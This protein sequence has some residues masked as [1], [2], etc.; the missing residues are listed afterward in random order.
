MGNNQKCIH[1][2]NVDIGL[3]STV[4]QDNAGQ[5]VSGKVA[6]RFDLPQPPLEIERSR[7]QY[8][9]VSGCDRSRSMFNFNTANDEDNSQNGQKRPLHPT[10][11]DQSNNNNCLPNLSTLGEHCDLLK[12]LTGRHPQKAPSCVPNSKGKLNQHPRLSC[13]NDSENVHSNRSDPSRRI[14]HLNRPQFKWSPGGVEQQHS[15]QQYNQQQYKQQ[16]YNQQQYNQ[17]QYEQELVV[18]NNPICQ[19]Q[20]PQPIAVCH[21]KHQYE[22]LHRQY[23]HHQ[24]QYVDRQVH[25]DTRSRDHY[26]QSRRSS[27]QGPSSS[28]RRNFR[29]LTDCVCSGKDASGYEHGTKGSGNLEN[30][31]S[32]DA[33]K[34]Y[35]SKKTTPTCVEYIECPASRQRDPVREKKPIKKISKQFIECPGSSRRVKRPHECDCGNCERKIIIYCTKRSNPN[36]NNPEDYDEYPRS[37]ER[38]V[39]RND[40][41]FD[42]ASQKVYCMKMWN[43][44]T[45]QYSEC[46]SSRQRQMRQKDNQQYDVI[47]DESVIDSRNVYFNGPI[48]N[49]KQYVECPSLKRVE[50]KRQNKDFEDARSYF[51]RDQ[52]KLLDSSNSKYCDCNN[53]E[54]YPEEMPY[55]NDCDCQ[56]QDTPKV[57]LFCGLDD[58]DEE[59]EKRSEADDADTDATY[60]EMQPPVE[61][62]Q[63]DITYA[64]PQ[65]NEASVETEID[66][67]LR[68]RNKEFCLSNCHPSCKL[69]Q[70]IQENGAEYSDSCVETEID[71]TLNSRSGECMCEKDDKTAKPCNKKE[72]PKGK[73]ANPSAPTVKPKYSMA[74]K[75]LKP[76]CKCPPPVPDKSP[77]KCRPTSPNPKQRSVSAGPPKFCGK[78]CNKVEDVSGKCIT[79]LTFAILLIF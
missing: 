31:P 13:G 53:F 49:S 10:S 70:E 27:F 29:D 47:E 58:W 79:V 23:D 7:L 56:S 77:N 43:P 28:H 3:P 24:P 36:L 17:Q 11:D 73:K 68:C 16:Q 63:E 4:N 1:S 71:M 42:D 76:I 12:V 50:K 54:E 21:N 25:N 2:E 18:C 75:K 57:K 69:A 72:P 19:N 44:V 60:Y 55:T 9:S 78:P 22:D 39:P 62:S 59:R 6:Y 26:P 64:G 66:M 46:P 65:Y 52:D 51:G 32:R 15:Q 67:T 30:H 35:R 48:E 8:R 5:E 34:T 14:F 38:E 37:K 20:I 40:R 45:E 61:D 33:K 74:S 41:D